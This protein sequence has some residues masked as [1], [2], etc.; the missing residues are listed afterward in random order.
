MDVN[1]PHGKCNNNFAQLRLK[2]Q[3]CSNVKLNVSL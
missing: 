3:K 2:M 1:S